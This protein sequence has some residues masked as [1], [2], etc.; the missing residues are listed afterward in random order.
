MKPIAPKP[1]TEV[2]LRYYTTGFNSS[3]V[4]PKRFINH[5]AEPGAANTILARNPHHSEE[6]EVK[7]NIKNSSASAETYNPDILS[8]SSVSKVHNREYSK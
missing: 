7:P 6:A 8:L 5:I 1:R 4:H 2:D 3:D